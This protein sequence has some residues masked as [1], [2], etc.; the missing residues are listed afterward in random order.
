[1]SQRVKNEENENSLK[2]FREKRNISLYIR[3]HID[4]L[5]KN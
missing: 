3:I 4:K 5:D 2:A 1:M